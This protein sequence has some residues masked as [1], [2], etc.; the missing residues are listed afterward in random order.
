ME[1]GDHGVRFRMELCAIASVVFDRPE[2]IRSSAIVQEK[3]A[4]PKAP[5]RRSPEC[6]GACPALDDTVSQFRTH[7]MQQQI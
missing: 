2:K 7:V 5:K 4:L 3:N 1:V 6:I